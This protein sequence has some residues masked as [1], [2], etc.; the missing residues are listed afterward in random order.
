MR[1]TQTR[2]PSSTPISAISV[3][4]STSPTLNSV[5]HASV[6]STAKA[7]SSPPTTAI[8]SP[9]P[10]STTLQKAKPNGRPIST[11]A[12]AASVPQKAPASTTSRAGWR[13]PSICSARAMPADSA[14][15]ATTSKAFTSIGT[16]KR[17]LCSTLRSISTSFSSLTITRFSRNT[18]NNPMRHN[19]IRK[20][21]TV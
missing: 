6:L 15:P 17:I 7:S 16:S 13:S 19:S 1:P 20:T 21:D 4:G 14:S 11:A 8:I 12:T 3:S 9:I 10:R 2:T 18:R 5:R